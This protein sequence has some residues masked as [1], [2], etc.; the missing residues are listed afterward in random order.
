V[1]VSRIG[2]FLLRVVFKRLYPD[3]YPKE[4]LRTLA[5]AEAIQKRLPLLMKIFFGAAGD[6]PRAMP[7]STLMRDTQAM[8]DELKSD[9][10]LLFCRYTLSCK[11]T[12][13]RDGHRLEMDS[14]GSGDLSGI[15]IKGDADHTYSIYA[16]VGECVL[17]K[18]A[19]VGS[20]RGRV[21]DSLDLR[22]RSSLVTDNMGTIKI[23][24]RKVSTALPEEL[25]RLVVFVSACHSETVEISVN[26]S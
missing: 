14:S 9:C 19:M 1:S 4:P 18:V 3:C 16:N 13:E 24:R 10:N 17:D 8:L 21:V 26:P 12:L 2:E 11:M 6:K 20:L 7:S 25:A 15:S 23:K 22:S 5:D